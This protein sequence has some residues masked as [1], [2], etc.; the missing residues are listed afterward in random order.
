MGKMR[1]SYKTV[2]GKPEGRQCLRGYFEMGL[3]EIGWED[4]EWIH[5][6]QDWDQ[7]R[8][9]GNTVINLPPQ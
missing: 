9:C 8:D 3:K 2:F 4:V 1:N 7:W 6:A 5:M